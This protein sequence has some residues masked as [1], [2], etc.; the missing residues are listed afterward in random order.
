ML[1]APLISTSSSCTSPFAF[2]SPF[3]K[4]VIPMLVPPLA[5]D[6]TQWG[7]SALIAAVKAVHWVVGVAA[8]A[9]V[10]S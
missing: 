2:T 7:K 5:I 8:A 10:Y 9:T 1:S 4:P 3:L 6:F